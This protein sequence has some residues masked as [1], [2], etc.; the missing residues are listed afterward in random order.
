MTNPDKMISW[1]RTS[2]GEEEIH[3][4]STSILNENISQ[5]E[6]TA[7]F[8]RNISE[9]LSVP[10]VVAT[11]SGSMA[12]LMALI[13]AGVGPGDEVIVPE[14]T[15]VAS[16]NAIRFVGATPVFI[17]ANIVVSSINKRH[18]PSIRDIGLYAITLAQG[19]I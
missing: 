9:I 11:T 12:I 13:A 4:I 19:Q 16:A 15:W 3:S 14:V 8:E 1:W 10:Y 2:L 5:G 6:V 18:S 7:E 17:P